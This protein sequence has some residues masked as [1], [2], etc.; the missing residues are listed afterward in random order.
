MLN[1]SEVMVL[2]F[3]FADTDVQ[4]QLVG[5]ALLQPAYADVCGTSLMT[6][7]DEVIERQQC[8]D[9]M[10]IELLSAAVAD[11]EE[12]ALS[13]LDTSIGDLFWEAHSR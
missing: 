2:C 1:P 3:R 6:S 10:L 8:K 7:A 9:D 4:P 13:Q 11:V 12:V 5:Q